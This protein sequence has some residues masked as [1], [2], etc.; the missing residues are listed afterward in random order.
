MRLLGFMASLWDLLLEMFLLR[1]CSDSFEQVSHIVEMTYESSQVHLVFEKEAWKLEDI[2]H[3]EAFLVL[4]FFI[5]SLHRQ[6][7]S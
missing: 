1:C 4:C 6:A 7:A 3:T 2:K 5:V